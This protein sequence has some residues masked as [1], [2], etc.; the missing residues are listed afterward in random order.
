MACTRVRKRRFIARRPIFVSQVRSSDAT[1]RCVTPHY[2]ATE[3]LVKGVEDA[4]FT[5]L[6]QTEERWDEYDSY[7]NA[8]THTQEWPDVG[9]RTETSYGYAGSFRP[10]PHHE[11]AS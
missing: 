7:G 6:S 5:H 11:L 8:M 4:G 3:E 2:L 9:A 1:T 10:K